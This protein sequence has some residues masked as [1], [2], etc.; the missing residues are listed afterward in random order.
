MFAMLFIMSKLPT[1]ILAEILV[2]IVAKP[3]KI[4]DND[5][6]YWYLAI[7]ATQIACSCA[8]S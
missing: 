8:H 1:E 6:I 7:T 4:A 3:V 2:L 5:I